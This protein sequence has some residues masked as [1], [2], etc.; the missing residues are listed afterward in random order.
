MQFNKGKILGYLLL[1]ALLVLVVFMSL[2]VEGKAAPAIESI[3]IEGSKL[4]NGNDYL[5]YSRLDD[6][7]SYKYLSVNI[8]KD[9]LEKH[10]Y[11]SEASVKN[12]SGR[13]TAVVTEK[14]F[15]AIVNQHGK[16]FFITPAFELLPFIYG[17]KDVDY[18]IISGVSLTDTLK[19]FTRVRKNKD[20][21]TSFKVID[22]LELTDRKLYGNLSE[23]ICE[24]S[25][26]MLVQ[27][28]N[29]DFPVILGKGD[30]IKKI[31]YFGKLW[32]YFDGKLNR[33]VVNYIDLRYEKNIFL[34]LNRDQTRGQN[35]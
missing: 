27:F 9:R 23:I 20:I 11:I 33:N 18:P 21:K 16:S 25:R 13:I 22:A 4:L 5:K 15:S 19:A 12:V 10:P 30:E 2:N 7:E 28:I 1:T 26:G 17:T 32:S 3:S 14:K 34:G 29:F 8:I 6:S 31:A 24:S 35:S